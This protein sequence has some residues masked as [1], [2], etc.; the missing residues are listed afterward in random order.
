MSRQ[1]DY[2]GCILTVSKASVPGLTLEKHRVFRENKH[3]LVPKIEDRLSFTLLPELD[4]QDCL[5]QNIKMPMI[6]TNRSLVNVYYLKENADGSLE[7]ISSSRGTDQVVKDQASL[8]KK[9][10][11]AQNLLNYTKL[12]PTAEGCDWVSVQALEIG[13]SIP[14]TLKKQGAEK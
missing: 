12:T 1:T 10:V 4:G 9:N 14:E 7:Y 2:E 5:L 11:I 3:V 13:G 6:M 8:I